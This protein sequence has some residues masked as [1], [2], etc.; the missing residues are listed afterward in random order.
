MIRHVFI[1]THA[2]RKQSKE[3][4]KNT[5]RQNCICGGYMSNFVSSIDTARRTELQRFVSRRAALRL[6]LQFVVS[7]YLLSRRT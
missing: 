7:V 6:A 1:H 5:G 4:E 2:S 3:E